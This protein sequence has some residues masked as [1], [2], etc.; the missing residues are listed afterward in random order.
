MN[1]P[2]VSHTTFVR[3]DWFACIRLQLRGAN[4]YVRWL[5]ELFLVTTCCTEL[6]YATSATSDSVWKDRKK[7]PARLIAPGP[8]VILPVQVSNIFIILSF[9]PP[10]VPTARAIWSAL[11]F[12]SLDLFFNG[13]P[14]G[15]NY[16]RM[17]R[18]KLRDCGWSICPSFS[19]S[20]RDV[21]IVNV[22][23]VGSFADK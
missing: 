18:T 11:L 19:H 23:I 22:D 13:P 14:S 9:S 10:S 6:S 4:V 7:E 17:Y 16:H 12:F 5:T 15:P 8:T 3:F 1:S 2:S 21:A 20:Y